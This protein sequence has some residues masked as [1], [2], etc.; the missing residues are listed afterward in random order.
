[1][2][3]PTSY[4]SGFWRLDSKIRSVVLPPFSCRYTAITISTSTNPPLAATKFFSFEE[5]ANNSSAPS[6]SALAGGKPGPF[7]AQHSTVPPPR[8]PAVPSGRC[9]VQTQP[10]ATSLRHVFPPPRADIVP[11]PSQESGPIYDTQFYT[12]Q[13]RNRA[14]GGSAPLSIYGTQFSTWPNILDPSSTSRY[15]RPAAAATRARGR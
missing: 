14:G 12:I 5:K 2:G 1:M 10:D 6:G 13:F 8:C 7:Y 3:F 4:S 9:L 15:G 11:D